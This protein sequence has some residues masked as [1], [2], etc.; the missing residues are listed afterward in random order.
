MANVLVRPGKPQE[1]MALYEQSLR[2][3]QELGDVREV[4]VTQANFSQLLLQQGESRR[5]L[6]MAWDAYT[7][8]HRSGFSRD[9]QIMQEL[10]ISVKGEDLGPEQFDAL[11]KEVISGPQPEWL[12]HVQG[13]IIVQASRY[14]ARTV[15]RDRCQ[16][17]H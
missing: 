12:A 16:Y 1:A 3:K 11:W 8:L 6:A 13:G 7:S 15:E 5:A 17:H 9:A 4:A 14:L 2:T 10:L